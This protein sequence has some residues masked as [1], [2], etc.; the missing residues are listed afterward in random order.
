M[1]CRAQG[2]M[3]QQHDR[4]RFVCY[5]MAQTFERQRLRSCSALLQPCP[6]VAVYIVAMLRF[7]MGPPTIT[8][9]HKK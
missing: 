3:T 1:G 5:A 2:P 9:N 6:L 4:K 8:V 7:V